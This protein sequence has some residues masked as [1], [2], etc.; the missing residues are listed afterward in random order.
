[1]E[2]FLIVPTEILKTSGILSNPLELAVT[3]D[4]IS[5]AIQLND[6]NKNI[7]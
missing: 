4:L 5:K 1:M 6:E 3:W 2:L 7:G